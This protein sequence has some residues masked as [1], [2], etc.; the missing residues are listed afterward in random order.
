MAEVFHHYGEAFRNAHTLCTQQH[1][2]MRAI[3]TCRTAELGGHLE[4]CDRCG[5][6]VLRFHSCRNRHCPKCQTLAKERWAE[7]R[8]AELLPVPYFHVVFTL[9][10][11]LNP[12]AQ[13]NPQA[14]YRLLFQAAA[15]TLQTF[16]RDPK[17]LGGE[18]GITMVL[19]TWGQN[20]NQH[21]HVHGLVT[22]GALSG[23]GERWI[24]AKRGFLFPVR[25]LSKV[26]RGKYLDAL[27]Q[28]FE[29]GELRFAG[30]TTTLAPPKAFTLL[31]AKLR[32]EDWVV[33]SK[34]PFA[35][36]EQVVAYLGRYTH[37]IAISNE[38][39]LRLEQGT[40]LFRWRD[41]AHGHKT[42]TMN[43]PA[44]EFIRRFLL[45]VLPKGF[46]RIRH[47]G[48]LANR[49]RAEHLA[50]CRRALDT[51]PP[52]PAPTETVEAFLSR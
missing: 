43:L 26:F 30:P 32:A 18:I 15:E 25:A 40:V 12:L 23:D 16:G 39:L 47:F 37:R 10:H 19:H 49:H 45:H 11:I 24:A 9:P 5:A 29:R 48:L 13:R 46:M 31:L 20:L 44:E 17:W 14:I 36:P 8:R 27:S 6:Q 51:P 42:K 50:R 34:R 28:A 35:G 38:R 33:Y 1:R 2:V 7:A 22:G 41:Y 21:L 52:L 3:E 4:Q